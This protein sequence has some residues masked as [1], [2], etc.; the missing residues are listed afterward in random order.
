M[1]NNECPWWKNSA[2]A[3]K[4]IKIAIGQAAMGKFIR[5]EIEMTAKDNS[6][7]V[8]DFS[9]KP[10]LNE[11]G[12]VVM[13]I[14]EARNITEIKALQQEFLALQEQRKGDIIKA[15][16]AAQERERAEISYELHDN[17]NQIL[18]AS[19]LHFDV[20]Q[21]EAPKDLVPYANSAYQQVQSAIDE[22]RMISRSLNPS[23]L[24]EIGLIAAIN[25][26]AGVINA[27]GK[28]SIITCFD[29]FFDEDKVANELKICVFRI[30]QEL[31]SNALKHAH[32]TTIT[33]AVSLLENEVDLLFNDNGVGL[34]VHRIKWGLGLRNIHN[35]VELF[36][37][38]IKLE[39]EFGKG[40]SVH[41]SIPLN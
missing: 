3:R 31:M 26:M 18:V 33:L 10:M 16:L 39:S 7:A 38:K 13:L 37:G 25:D 27:A 41:I 34:D 9:I 5:F 8:I 28:T 15:I 17:V 20:C 4:K 21:R 24:N 2:H 12:E 22:I 29:S 32:S 30:L 35:R 23:I 40:C 36:R 1:D 11:M 6:R 19:L 14:P